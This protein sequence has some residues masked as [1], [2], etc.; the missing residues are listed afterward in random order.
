MK[1]EIKCYIKNK[2]IY[3][4]DLQMQKDRLLKQIKE[5]RLEYFNYKTGG[6]EIIYLD[7]FDKIDFTVNLELINMLEV[8]KNEN[9]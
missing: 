9:E 2:L 4:I 5:N 3:T 6:T 8:V 7:K 1:V